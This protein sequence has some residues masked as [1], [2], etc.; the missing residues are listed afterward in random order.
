MR[1]A[2]V[3][4]G[5]VGGFFG[6]RLAAAGYD[7]TFVAR[8]AHLAAMQAKGLRV[9]SQ[10][11]DMHI[12]KPQLVDSPTKLGTV[13]LVIV[14]VKLWDTE[15]LARDLAP[16]VARGAAVVSFQNGVA[17]DEILASALP[18]E[19][20]I[21]G[22]SYISAFIEEPGVV[23][24]NGALQRLLFGEYDG[25]A[26]ARVQAFLEACQ[27]AGINA[28]IST[29]I[30]RQ[31][32]EK[33]VFLVGLS[34]STTSI[35]QR[36]GAV[37]E[38]PRSRVFLHDLMREVVAVGRARGV[39]LDETFADDRLS[40]CDTLPA[41]MTSSM[42]ND[43]ERGNRLEVAWLSGGV[44]DYGAALGVATPRNRAVADILDI[45]APGKPR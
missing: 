6:A 16:V 32:W 27:K 10:L 36:I 33:F 3:G 37:R 17:K 30:Q 45:Y 31:I 21:G 13:D 43:L 26:S 44:A 5:G 39:A 25:Q 40:F 8:G 14:A 23:R 9:L 41:D 38:N 2:V 12:E 4:A 11:G 24:H 1:I 35:R 15:Q 29:D 22:C 28:E 18:K 19:A 34:G 42:H 7:V 20:L